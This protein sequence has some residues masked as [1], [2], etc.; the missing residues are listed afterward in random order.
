[1]IEHDQ[2][3]VEAA[4]VARMYYY[5]NLTTE[6]IAQQ[7]NVSRSKVSRLLSF[8]KQQGLVEIRVHDPQ[9]H[10]QPLEAEIQ[11]RY[12]VAAKVVSTPHAATPSE[13][14]EQVTR[15]AANYLNALVKDAHVLALSWGTTLS[16]MSQ[17]LVALE[18]SALAVV[19]L[20]GAGNLYH[21][22]SLYAADIIRRFAN[23]YG[24]KTHLLPVPAYF[25]TAST[26]RALWRERSLQPLFALHR[27][28]DVALFSL[29]GV[30]RG[31]PRRIYTRGYLSAHDMNALGAAGVVGSFAT[32][33]YPIDG[34]HRRV[35]LNDRS[36]G[37][38]LD[39]FRAV[40]RRLCVLSGQGKVRSLHAALTGGLVSDLV[41]DD[42]TA[43]A[44]VGL[45]DRHNRLSEDDFG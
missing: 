44:L 27:R 3:L 12:E 13:R 42:T 26:R 7:L 35:A 34:D 21:G 1:M 22:S 23:N 25:D 20:S 18:R 31:R 11:R 2:L 17:H 38:D 29:E 9:R 4:R 37:P 16:V 30:H 41:T 33:F 32:V 15:F 28:S 14:L 5:Q 10:P 39:V 45:Y 24:A 8:A 19:Q 40:P 43:E 6:L 36:S